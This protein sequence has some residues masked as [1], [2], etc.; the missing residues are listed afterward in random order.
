MENKK[1]LSVVFIVIAIVIIIGGIFLLNKNK[2][3]D[4]SKVTK[5]RREEG[6]EKL[7]E[8]KYPGYKE[9]LSEIQKE[10][11]NWT[12]TILYT[13]LDWDDV[14]FNETAGCHGGNLVDGAEGGV[15]TGE[16]LC[17][18]CSE[19]IYQAP[20]WKC[21]SKAGVAYQ[22]DPRN[23]LNTEN[24]FQFETLSYV[25]D[26]YTTEG[27]EKILEKSFMHDKTIKDFYKETIPD[28]EFSDK[29][30]SEIIM[31]IAKKL[32]VSPY[33]LAIRLVQGNIA[34]TGDG[35]VLMDAVKGNIEGFTGL[36]NYFNIGSKTTG[37][38]A[39]EKGLN[40]AKEE[41]W[42]TPEKSLEAGAN[43]LTE[44]YIQIGQD[45][46]YLEKFDV[47]DNEKDGLYLHQYMQNVHGASTEAEKTVDIYINGMMDSK[48]N[49]IIPVYENMPK[50]T[51]KPNQKEKIE[52][53]KSQEDVLNA[54]YNTTKERVELLN[55]I[56][57]KVITTL[58]KGAKVSVID[59]ENSEWSKVMLF[60]GIQG[61]VKSKSIDLNNNASCEFVEVVEE[62]EL[63]NKP[64]DKKLNKLSAG[65][66]LNILEKNVHTDEQGNSWDKVE[67]PEGVIA[68]SLNNNLKKIEKL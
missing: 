61:Y 33:H 21:A 11:P 59:S 64:E 7:D 57:G 41:N 19:K 5:Q 68:Y 60:N 56:D 34:M 26:M 30:F 12:F 36:F 55:N 6:Y 13:D 9:K 50:E 10:H 14:I 65:E 25:D 48:F 18:V 29:K 31:E 27:V 28:N 35:N 38:D 20:G 52:V 15:G 39:R 44:N 3:N 63:Y 51:E 23:F 46:L 2:S 47:I 58:D 17:P 24:I 43:Y 67:T 37:A 16:W 62:Q 42:T 8:K 40:K 49:F 4:S 32:K 53:T 22:M 45:T 66:T 1:T 54:T